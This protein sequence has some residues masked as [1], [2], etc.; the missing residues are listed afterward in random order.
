MRSRQ[1]SLSLVSLDPMRALFV[2]ISFALVVSRCL[3]ASTTWP[4]KPYIEVRA[5]AY[6]RDGDIA[7]P[8]I[9]HA[10]LDRSVIN[11]RGV[12][13]AQEQTRRLIDAVTGKRPEPLSMTA[14]FN[15]R[16][17]FVFYDAT[18]KPVA[19][20]ELCF[21]CHNAEAQP[22]RKGQVYDVDALEKLARDLNLPL[23]PK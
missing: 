20:V 9:K 10:R 8:I 22:F 1:R 18:K 14:C 5:Y 13:L 4:D 17:A 12:M 21:E 7:L 15:P 3:V 11:K 2:A 19:W 6:N 23:V 16:H